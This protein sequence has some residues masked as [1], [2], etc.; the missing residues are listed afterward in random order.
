M[1]KTRINKMITLHVTNIISSRVS[2][3]HGPK[4]NGSRSRGFPLT[5]LPT[6][7]E[8]IP[9]PQKFRNMDFP[10]SVNGLP[11]PI[12]HS[13]TQT[14]LVSTI[15]VPKIS[16]LLTLRFQPKTRHQRPFGWETNDFALNP[17]PPPPGYIYGSLPFQHGVYNVT[18]P[19]RVPPRTIPTAVERHREVRGGEYCFYQL[20]LS[21]NLR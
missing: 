12:Q 16:Q 21:A 19:T 15:P 10:P 2:P 5:Q 9:P 4:R 11:E 18:S 14:T 3:S 13:A 20:I 7:V 17:P 8:T 1:N 6:R